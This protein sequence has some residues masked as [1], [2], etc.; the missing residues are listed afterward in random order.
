MCPQIEIQMRTGCLPNEESLPTGIIAKTPDETGVYYTQTKTPYQLVV[1]MDPLENRSGKPEIAV[2]SPLFIGHERQPGGE[3]TYWGPSRKVVS[4][5]TH[6]EGST[7][8]S[9]TQKLIVRLN[10]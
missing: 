10:K 8:L 4:L 7:A 1:D 6:G 9:A 3:E 5:N 2:S